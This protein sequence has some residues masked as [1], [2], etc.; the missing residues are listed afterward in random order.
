MQQ[1][2]ELPSFERVVEE[3][4]RTAVDAP[5]NRTGTNCRYR[6]RDALLSAFGL[7]FSQHPSFLDFQRQINRKSVRHNMAS[8][9]G[10]EEVPSDNQIRNI[11]DGVPA[12]HFDLVFDR[13][14]T[15]LAEAGELER[16]RSV[17]NELLL[18]IDGTEYHRSEK[19][20]CP[21]CHTTHHTD[22]RV[23]YWHEL[24]SPAIVK[25][26]KREV[27]A[28]SPEF[29]RAG[30]GERK[31]EGELT[32]AKRWID[33]VGAGLSPHS[34]TVV[35]DDLYATQSF[36]SRVREHELNFLCVCKPQS[37]KHLNESI[38]S[39]RASGDVHGY[40]D[41]VWTGKERRSITYE[42]AEDVSLRYTENSMLVNWFAVEIVREHDG[43]RIY[44]NS[45]ITNHRITQE[46][47]PQLVEAGRARWKVENEDINTLKTKGYNLE[48][49]FGHGRKHL[50]ET[51]A[52]LNILAFLLHT[53]L[54]LYDIRYRRLRLERGHRSKFFEELGTLLGYVYFSD[55]Q[56]LIKFMIDQLDLPDPGG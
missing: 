10:V 54:D 15:E 53:L 30:D 33:R 45:F 43:K 26:G 36:L 4:R 17:G 49:N 7:F 14:F 51:L 18:T 39:L 5:D 9:F 22:G 48:H 35:G 37:H 24:L 31:E 28:L 50:A 44:R 27:L 47:I 13:I 40:T 55:W 42:W 23:S 34:V 6:I 32:A 21:Y 19:I 11:L 2:G 38:D 16:F 8:L 3:I 25:P 1:G 52:T 20:S 12:R 46:T 29:V 41:Q 56:S